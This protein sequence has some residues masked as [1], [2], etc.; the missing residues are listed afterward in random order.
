MGNRNMIE[1]MRRQQDVLSP[2]DRVDSVI[3]IIYNDWMLLNLL[4]LDVVESETVVSILMKIDLALESTY[5]ASEKRINRY[6]LI[7]EAE[8]LVGAVENRLSDD[9]NQDYGQE[10]RQSGALSVLKVLRVNRGEI[11]IDNTPKVNGKDLLIALASL[12]A[13]F[14]DS[15]H[16]S[17]MQYLKQYFYNNYVKLGEYEYAF[18]NLLNL[19]K[20]EG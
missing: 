15:E 3:E 13:M 5:R 17:K 9:I 8:S 6:E 1:N 7:G 20:S 16:R 10:L 4:E 19:W 18:T 2:A 14:R 11:N 12:G